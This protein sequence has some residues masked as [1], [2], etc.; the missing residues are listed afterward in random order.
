MAGADRLPDDDLAGDQLELLVPAE[1]SCVGQPVI[2]VHREPSLLKHLIHLRAILRSPRG[3]GQRLDIETGYTA[4]K[5]R[6][7]LR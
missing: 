6:R 4:R 1:N 5:I 7:G 3:G 2:F